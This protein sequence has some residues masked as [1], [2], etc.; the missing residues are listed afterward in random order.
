[1]AYVFFK[2][3]ANERIWNAVIALGR[4]ILSEKAPESSTTDV[5]ELL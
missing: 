3:E 4:V 5:K 2:C 1:M